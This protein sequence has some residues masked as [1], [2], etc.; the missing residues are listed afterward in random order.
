M[1]SRQWA[2]AI[3]ILSALL[4]GLALSFAMDS[5]AL[6]MVLGAA[7]GMTIGLVVDESSW[8]NRPGEFG[9]TESRSRESN[10]GR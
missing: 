7:I 2:I 10:P 5:F 3:G 6:G 9:T 4:A 1:V 8:V